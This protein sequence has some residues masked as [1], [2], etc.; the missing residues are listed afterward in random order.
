MR[1]LNEKFTDEEHKALLEAKGSKTWHDYIL[2]LPKISDVKVLLT[3]FPQPDEE[4]AS[5]DYALKLSRWY[6]VMVELFDD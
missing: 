1:S 6:K 2:E 5:V 4:D 3:T